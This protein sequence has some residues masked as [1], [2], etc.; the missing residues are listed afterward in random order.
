[1]TERFF[2]DRLRY[3]RLLATLSLDELGERVTT[4]RQYLHQLETGAKEPSAEMR[5]ALADALGVT[6]AF[7]ARP[8]EASVAEADCHF[9]RYLTAPRAV[10]AHATARGTFVEQLAAA[11]ETR[12]RLPKINFPHAPS[13]PTDMVEVEAWAAKARQYWRLGADAP[14]A[15]MTRVL[16]RFGALVVSFGDI[17]DRIDALS[18]S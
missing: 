8:H 9:R 7:F 10:L 11:L 17:S 12:L 15:N 3:A 14:I 6:A 4:S 5:L 2:G 13:P 18:I 16:E 1:M